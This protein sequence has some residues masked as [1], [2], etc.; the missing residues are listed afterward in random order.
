MRQ[1]QDHCELLIQL[2]GKRT[3]LASTD[4]VQRLSRDFRN[5]FCGERLTA[6]WSTTEQSD[7]AFAL[8]LYN[9]IEYLGFR[10]VLLHERVDEVLLW[11]AKYKRW[12]CL[13][14]PLNVTA[15]I[16]G[17]ATYAGKSWYLQL[18]R[19]TNAYPT[20]SLQSRIQGQLGCI[21]QVARR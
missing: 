5:S 4:G 7:K 6:T 15:T 8:T 14:A 13:I 12:E 16:Q 10:I 21:L 19:A 1:L 20:S 18:L 3:E 2:A 11:L 17:E 9:V